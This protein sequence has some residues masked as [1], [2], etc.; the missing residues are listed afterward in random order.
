VC[1]DIGRQIAAGD[2][3]IVG[4]MIE[5]HL[6]EGRQDLKEGCAL[7]YG[8]SITDACIAWDDSVKVL[9]G[10]AESV[11]ARRVTRGSGN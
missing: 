5:S 11:K 2:A 9:E 1:A 7:T 6:V 4:V 10:L 8:Q 3:R